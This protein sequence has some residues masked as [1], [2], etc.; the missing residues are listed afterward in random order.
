M[1]DDGVEEG[2]SPVPGN[3]DPTD[4]EGN[5][6]FERP[7]TDALIHAERKEFRHAR[8]K[9]RH[10]DE[11]G[12]ITGTYSDNPIVN[13]LLYDVEFD[14][15]STRE[16]AAN[17]IAANLYEQV[18]CDGY[19]HSMFRG[20]EDFRKNLDAVPKSNTFIKTKSG[21][22]RM[23]QTTAGW[24][25]LVQWQDGQSQWIPLRILKESNPVDVAEFVREKGLIDEP[26]F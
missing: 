18:D 25:F 6:L 21:K 22:R 14:N 10:R 26:A 13:T 24:D 7:L 19:N 15:G 8:V 2:K 9:K 20:I 3:N 23:R 16:Y 5:A 12:Q 4:D 1:Y 11:E 17:V